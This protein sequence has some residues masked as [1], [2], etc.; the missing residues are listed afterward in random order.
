MTTRINRKT[1]SK[2]PPL[3]PKVL[4]EVES[5][6]RGRGLE[7]SSQS[8]EERNAAPMPEDVTGEVFARLVGLNDTRRVRE[9]HEAGIIQRSGK[10]RYPLEG[11]ALYCENLRTNEKSEDVRR[12]EKS[13]ADLTSEKAALARTERL[14]LEG[15]SFDAKTITHVLGSQLAST[16][17]RLLSIPNST[18][19]SVA[20]ISDP[21]SCRKIL[22]DAIRE[23]LS[24]LAE[25]FPS[26][27]IVARYRQDHDQHVAPDHTETPNL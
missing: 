22:S 2:T 21:E 1:K 9:L 18:A 8:K 7:S 25:A 23:A 12:W 14:L 24:D 5:P 3:G 26:A 27:A 19:A 13:R 20:E 11:V 10:D 4:P 17:A 6:R 16:R 15:T